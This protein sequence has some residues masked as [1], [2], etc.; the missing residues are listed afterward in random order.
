MGG[1]LLHHIKGTTNHGLESPASGT[2]CA[3]PAEKRIIVGLSLFL[4]VGFEMHIARSGCR[5]VCLLCAC[6]Q[7]YRRAVDAAWAALTAPTSD[8]SSSSGQSVTTTIAVPTEA[9]Q[10]VTLTQQEQWD[11]EQVHL[12]AACAAVI[13]AASMCG[14]LVGCTFLDAH[15]AACRYLSFQNGQASEDDSGARLHN[16]QEGAGSWAPT[17][18]P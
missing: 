4:M 11:L 12:H 7:V 9:K 1:P 5:G 17:L 3:A 18:M 10:A 2:G 13:S 16:N 6:M 15:C 14:S 8:S